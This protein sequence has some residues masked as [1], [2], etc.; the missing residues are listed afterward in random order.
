MSDMAVRTL[1][2][3]CENWTQNETTETMQM[4]VIKLFAT[5]TLPSQPKSEERREL[6]T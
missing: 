3:A 2:Y 5:Q 4:T 6:N 1:L